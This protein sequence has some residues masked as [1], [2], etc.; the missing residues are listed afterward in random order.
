M[1][2]FH[3]HLSFSGETQPFSAYLKQ[4]KKPTV[5]VNLNEKLPAIGRREIGFGTPPKN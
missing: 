1:V 4:M 2:I 5:Q 3:Y